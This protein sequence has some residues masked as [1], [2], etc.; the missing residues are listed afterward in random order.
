MIRSCKVSGIVLLAV[1]AAGTAG[2]QLPTGPAEARRKAPAK[3]AK[4]AGS[5]AA[6]FTRSAVALCNG[7]PVEGNALSLY[8]LSGYSGTP[9]IA[10]EALPAGITITPA[11][12]VAAPMPPDQSLPF[13]VG[14]FGAAP[15][16]QVVH[17]RVTDLA[18]A[19]DVVT[20]FNVHVSSGTLSPSVTPA[21]LALAAG[22]PSA[23]ATLSI[24]PPFDCLF[25]PVSVSFSGLPA[26]V[27]AAPAAPQLD[28]PAYSP[29]SVA[30]Q[31]AAS[32]PTGSYPVTV[33]F[34]APGAAVGHLSLTLNVTGSAP[35]FDFSI[36]ASPALLSV[37]AGGTGTVTVTAT[38][39]NGF[40][41][42]VDVPAP[43]V[44]G[45]TFTPSALS[46]PAGAG[47]AFTVAVAPG[48]ATG[49]TLVTLA[50][51][52]TGVA[53]S[54]T[55]SF[56]LE[57]RPGPDFSLTASPAAIS[58]ASGGA[59]TVTVGATSLNGFSGSVAVTAQA[60]PGL[61]VTPSSFTLA[62]GATQNVEL[63]VASGTAP[64]SL[65]AT[66]EGTAG[67][68]PAPRTASVQV[69]VTNAPDF[70]LT[71]SP[72]ALRAAAGSSTPV[73][74]LLTPLF[75]FGGRATLTVSGLPA[76]AAVTPASPTLEPGVPA[77]LT[78]RLA[79]SAAPGTYALAFRAA[80]VGGTLQRTTT[81]SLEVLPGQARFGV[82]VAPPSVLAAPGTPAAVTYTLTNLTDAPLSISSA[83]LV[84]RTLGGAELDASEES[85]P[86]R[87]PPRGSASYS[88]TVVASAADFGRAG[89]EPVLV[90]ERTF[91]SAPDALGAVASAAATVSARAASS[92]VATA[93][94]T[95]V[96]VLYPLGGTLVGRGD[97]LRAQGL[98]LGTGSGPVVVG[99]IYDGLLVETATVLL[100]NGT[101][102]VVSSSVSL[103]T[104]VE[105]THEIALA[106]LSPNPLSSPRVAVVV[107]EGV[108]TLGLVSP[109]AGSSFLPGLSVPTFAWVPVPGVARYAVGLKHASEG[110]AARRWFDAGSSDRWGPSSRLFSEL[111]EGDYD[112]V[113]RGSTG[114]DGASLAALA[115]GSPPPATVGDGWSVRSAAGRFSIGKLPAPPVDLGGSA[116]ASGDGVQLEWSPVAGARYLLLLY[117]AEGR[118]VD[119]GLARE[120]R[121]A[122]TAKRL[123]AKRPSRWRAVALDAAGRPVAWTGLL[124]LAGGAR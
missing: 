64:G 100:V 116:A 118:R 67:G 81:V 83:T 16:I 80:E 77:A 23:A 10:F 121:A 49:T 104:L 26:G 85:V 82:T 59:A 88:S 60:P 37:P 57:V 84:R 72:P 13:T 74:V 39:L 7:G 66:F 98:L 86:L 46:V 103:P 27:T 11:V 62:P 73:T 51:T 40:A 54:R 96:S 68:V 25:G 102:A 14:A 12:L 30:F 111:P 34:T 107:E 122:L 8:G 120:P 87:L 3:A 4:L 94:V 112:W 44:P 2:A 38:G 61:T 95:R 117:D 105:G 29:V 114:V 55:A 21:V 58:I 35:P 52:A 43:S 1:L 19:I 113:V 109:P 41:G 32:V 101:P 93:S 99:W 76:G 108:E 5:I 92:L 9:Q 124:S 110:E 75:G 56:S 24:S 78:L 79:P 28:H 69:A 90:F 18:N 36:S 70:G 47:R 97:A 71:V 115:G 65:A 15:G 53:G 50:G 91:R 42:T 22:G 33:G 45:V 48:T 20:T 63:R 123:E 31:A 119:S 6:P 17:A 106:V 89:S